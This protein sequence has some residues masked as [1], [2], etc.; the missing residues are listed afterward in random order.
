MCYF[1][2]FKNPEGSRDLNLNHFV[3]TFSFPI[4]SRIEFFYHLISFSDDD[5]LGVEGKV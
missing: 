5:K 2:G 4:M 1:T 3:Q